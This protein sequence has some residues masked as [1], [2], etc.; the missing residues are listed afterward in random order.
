MGQFEVLKKIQEIE[1]D[2]LK[3]F[4]KICKENN[5]MFFLRGGSVMGAVKYQGFIPWDDDVDI[6]VPR[7]DYDQLP[8]IFENK[9]IAGKY[10]VLCHQYCKELH[11]YFPRLFLLEDERIKLGLPRNT[12]LG[13]HLIDIIPLDGAPN[14]SLVRK[15]YYLKVYWYRFL[16][17]LGTTYKGDHIDMHSKKQKLL[18]GLFKKLGFA[19]LFSQNSVYNRLDRLYK[20]YDWKKQRY[21]GTVNA[22]LFTKEVMPSEIWGKGVFLRFEDTEYRVPSDYDSYLKR[23]YGENYYYEEPAEED[24]KSHIGG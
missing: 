4:N 12:N 14:N 22:S 20:R 2:A 9:I 21:A 11:C 15:V 10:Q 23:L 18:I 5:L 7:E 6:A 24:R 13:L 17:S 16:A 3:E 1:L 19:K 8:Q